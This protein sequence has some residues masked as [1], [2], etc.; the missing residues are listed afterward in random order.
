MQI[1]AVLWLVGVVWLNCIGW[2][3]SAL[4]QLNPAGYAVALLPAFLAAGIWLKK[5]P[6]QFRPQK[7]FRRFRRPLPALFLLVALLAFL[8]GLFY[9]PTNYDA[10]TYRLPR[11]LNWFMAGHWVWI[12]TVN[13]RMNWANTAWEWTAMPLLALT[14]S[15]R[16]FFLINALGFLLMP[17]LLV[18]I[19]RQ[20]GVARRVAWVWMWLL[21]LAYGYATQAGGIGNDFMG[22]LCGLL[23]VHFGLRARRSGRV[24]D[25]WLA[26]L[27]AALMTGVKMSNAPLALPCLVAVWPA[28]G[29]LRK[30]LAGSV[31]V[32][33]IAVLVSAMPTMALNQLY[34]GSWTGDPDNKYQMQIHRPSAALLGNSLL[35]AEQSFMP[36]ILPAAAKV[37]RVFDEKL[38]AAWLRLLHENFPRYFPNRLIELPS[39]EAAGL[40]LGITLS[41]LVVAGAAVFGL[42]RSARRKNILARLPPVALAAWVAT[43]F[44]LLKMG[45]ESAPRLLL[46]Y[47]PLALIPLLL[48]PAQDWL[49][50]RRTWRIFL[51]LAGLSVLPALV[52][53]PSRPLWPA[54]TVCD[55]LVAAH[56]GNAL[57]QRMAA[58]YSAY[59]RRN[60]VLA[61][62]RAALPADVREIGF[63][64]GGNDTDYSL[65]R[66]F[67]RRQVKYLRRDDPHFL[68]HP[69][70]V[71]WVVVK[72]EDWPK[73]S[74]E[75]LAAWAT[76]HHARMVVSVPVVE[77]VLL[78]PQTWT[79]LHFE[80]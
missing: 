57:W 79:V 40:G 35:I 58:V 45:S 1:L 63:I 72:E 46:S 75:P 38:P 62:V 18:S 10:L 67:G 56:P 4:H 25:V 44:Y 77:L 29:A 12:S 22:A 16:A 76:A 50:R 17:G 43:L 36:P 48:L 28:L 61:P 60:D 74:A 73:F 55:K 80:K 2:A 27:A 13:E 59:S 41:L 53:S 9:A 42:G 37:S 23:S 32:A 15:D 47:Y 24:G 8:G 39:E 69:D 7:N 33:G 49:W 14:R 68:A 65:W 51:V 70:E 34:T 11:M 71:E 30:N 21:P 52:L 5:N 26:L 54:R 3:L 20:L 31:A 6:P 66:P 64:A 19:F 78:G